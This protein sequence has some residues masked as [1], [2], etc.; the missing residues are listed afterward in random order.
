[1]RKH[2]IIAIVATIS[3]IFPSLG[4]AHVEISD[5]SLLGLYHLE[6]DC[7]DASGNGENLTENNAQYSVGKLGSFAFDGGASNN[8]RNC[9]KDDDNP[10]TLDT[11][12]ISTEWGVSLWIYTRTSSAN[13]N[14]WKIATFDTGPLRNAVSLNSDFMELQI[15]VF[16]GPANEYVISGQT[17]N[18][19]YHVVM[20]YDGS[21][22]TAYVDGELELTQARVITTNAGTWGGGIGLLTERSNSTNYNWYKGQIDE[23]VFLDREFTADEIADL[24]NSGAGE[25]ACSAVGCGTDAAT[26][27]A[28][29]VFF[30]QKNT[31]GGGLLIILVAGL[32]Y[33]VLKY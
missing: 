2:W 22:F 29:G 20:N 13:M 7:V 28:A 10:L 31:L 15:T 8:S 32:G 33:F 3:L 4:Y 12:Q 30:I 18:T 6:E 19:W 25:E 5:G 14:V 24:Y 9:Y 11:T 26:T 16:D 21:D 23:V 1:M 27:T 17:L